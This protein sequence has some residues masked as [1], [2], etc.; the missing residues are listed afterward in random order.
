MIN[1]STM[2]ISVGD[3]HRLGDGSYFFEEEV[4][5]YKW[6]V[7]MFYDRYKYLTFSQQLLLKNYLI[8]CAK[9]Q[10]INGRVFDLA[11][12][13]HKSIYD[14]TLKKM[15]E[16]Q[17]YSSKFNEKEFAE[18]IVINYLLKLVFLLNMT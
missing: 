1:N 16:M 7:D 3:N 5:A 6:C 15:M 4:Y 11:K 10:A 13:E 2:E 14:Q 12:L 18:G 17:E 9:I 8:I